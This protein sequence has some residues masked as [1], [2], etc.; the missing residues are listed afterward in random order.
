MFTIEFGIRTES[1]S[2]MI[3]DTVWSTRKL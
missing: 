1:V 3:L 2:L